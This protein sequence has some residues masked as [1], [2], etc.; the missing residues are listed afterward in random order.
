M[1]TTPL[2]IRE[3]LTPAPTDSADLRWAVETAAAMWARGDHAQ[4]MRWLHHAVQTA[5]ADGLVQRAQDLGRAAA[6]LDRIA[7]EHPPQE[8]VPEH[9]PR[10]GPE[11]VH[12]A[13]ASMSMKK[14]TPYKIA[15]DDITRLV[16]P[17]AKLL[18][19]C[20]PDAPS[21][22]PMDTDPEVTAPLGTPPSPS[23]ESTLRDRPRPPP[24]STDDESTLAAARSRR[25]PERTIVMEAFPDAPVSTPPSVGITPGGSSPPS[26]VSFRIGAPEPPPP[27]EPTRDYV[28]PSLP[29]TGAPSSPRQ[30]SSVPITME[31]PHAPLEALRALRVAIEPG[32]G[33][34]LS[35]VVLGDGEAAPEGTQEALLVPLAKR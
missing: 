15:P 27:L 10:V 7:R 28:S 25:A 13:S 6:E 8:A 18:A 12:P 14:T 33:T 11:E 19:Q 26:G 3:T 20:E 1:S 24:P 22:P 17:D 5:H 32:R 29:E 35:V 21:R 34:R 4:G 31:S 16:A 2:W 23:V 30:I 9:V